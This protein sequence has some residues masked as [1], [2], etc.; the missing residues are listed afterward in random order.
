MKI[1]LSL[2]IDKILLLILILSCEIKGVVAEGVFFACLFA[3][4]FRANNFRR[5]KKNYKP[6]IYII[7]A[8]I[9]LLINL[10]LH[11]YPDI[12]WRLVGITKC[13]CGIS[14][15]ILFSDKLC[16]KDIFKELFNILIVINILAAIGNITN[17]SSDSIFEII[18]GNTALSINMVFWPHIV[19]HPLRRIGVSGILYWISMIILGFSYISGALVVGIS[20][21]VIVIIVCYFIKIKLKVSKNSKK[22]LV[23]CLLGIGISFILLF[24]FN[25]TIRQVYLDIIAKFDISRTQIMSYGFSRRN[26]LPFFEQI[27]GSGDNRYAVAYGRII[28][29]HNF[30][31]ETLTMFG[32]VGIMV[33]IYETTSFWR[34]MLYLETEKKYLKP[35]IFS[36]LFGYMAFLIHPIYSTSFVFKIFFVLININEYYHTRKVVSSTKFLSRG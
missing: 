3:L 18:G 25:K 17:F 13:Y 7:I 10:L 30:I 14:I 27:W 28:E 31:V 5:W 29:A 8:Y 33:L 1:K 24:V 16:K 11:F 23:T 36:L 26:S 4:I 34:F 19:Y 15:V 12:S 9:I 21:L 2:D 32:F 35:I 20:L 6:F 22:I